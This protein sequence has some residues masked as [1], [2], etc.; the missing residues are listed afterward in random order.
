MTTGQLKQPTIIGGIERIKSSKLVNSVANLTVHE[1]PDAEEFISPDL[2][3]KKA[4]FTESAV[5]KKSHR[6]RM[7]A[8]K[9][10]CQ[11]EIAAQLF[12]D[13]LEDFPGAQR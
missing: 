5:P 12:D 4:V 7:M 6:Q 3:Q 13:E 11:L 2:P 1:E 10:M 9:K 8:M